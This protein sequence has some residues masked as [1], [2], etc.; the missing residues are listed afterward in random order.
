MSVQSAVEVAKTQERK[1]LRETEVKET[2]KEKDLD[3]K[4]EPIEKLFGDL[5]FMGIN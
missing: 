4:E 1:S 3:E 5:D 2:G